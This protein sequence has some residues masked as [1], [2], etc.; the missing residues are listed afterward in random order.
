[1]EVSSVVWGV[2]TGAEEQ[3]ELSTLATSVQCV[4]VL[5]AS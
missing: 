5:A 4:D 3:V 2:S 1:M